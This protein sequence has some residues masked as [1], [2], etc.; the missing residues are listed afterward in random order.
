MKGSQ[1]DQGNTPLD[2]DESEGLIP[3]H[4]A[5]HAEL[6]QWEATNIARAQEW[7]TQRANEVLDVDFLAELHKRMFGLT[8]EW[9]GSC[10]KS[11]KNIS[12]H[13][14]TQ[15]PMLMRDLVDNTRAQYDASTKAAAE[16]D[17]ITVR[18][19]HGLVR[20]H[21]WVNGNGRHARLATDLLLGQW[22]RPPFTWGGRSDLGSAGEARAAYIRSLKQ[23]DQ[24]EFAALVEFVR[25]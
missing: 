23:A 25:S 6:N 12:P 4:L 22:G 24:G 1:D 3:P 14:W 9:A 17:E 5:T 18:F 19:H 15:V 20:I 7:V 10:R 11:D 16:L 13:H 21:P 2:E 8:W